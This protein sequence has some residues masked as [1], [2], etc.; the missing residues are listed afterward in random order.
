MD[1]PKHWRAATATR[2]VYVPDERFTVSLEREP[3]ET[4]A[5]TEPR[6][7]VRLYCNT[8]PRYEIVADEPQK[9]AA[10]TQ[11]RQWLREHPTLITAATDTTAGEPD[12]ATDNGPTPRTLICEYCRE[13]FTPITAAWR[14]IFDLAHVRYACPSCAHVVVSVAPA[15]G[16]LDDDT[17]SDGSGGEC[18]PVT[19]ICTHC[20]RTF[21][22]KATRRIRQ[23]GP[24]ETWYYCSHCGVAAVGPPPTIGEA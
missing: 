3:V 12:D 15:P 1:G 7:S 8:D 24:T 14:V 21:T 18:A 10:H 17:P 13:R 22:P 23:R 19:L 11:L 6:W 4:A 16:V 9:A 2:Y 20:E 5:G